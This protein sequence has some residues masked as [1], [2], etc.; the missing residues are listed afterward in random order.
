MFKAI[1][2]GEQADIA[3]RIHLG[4]VPDTF[5]PTM[6]VFK[7][8]GAGVVARQSQMHVDGVAHRCVFFSNLR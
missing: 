7:I 5:Q 3:F 6:R 4:L 8:H 1:R 2:I